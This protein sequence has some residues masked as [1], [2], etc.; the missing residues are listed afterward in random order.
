MYEIAENMAMGTMC[1]YTPY[2]DALPH[3]KCVLRCCSNFPHIDLSDQEPD[4]HHPNACLS[5]RFHIYHLIACCAVHGRRPLDKRKICHMC[6]K[7]P[8][9]VTR[10]KLYT[11]K[12]LVMVETYIADFNTIIYIPEIKN[13]A[14]HLPNIRIISMNQCGK[15]RREAFKPFSAKQDV[16]CC[17]DYSERVVASF[18]HQIQSSPMS[19]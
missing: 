10:T 3:W 7:D 2:Q 6:F 18:A 8:A 4:R 12:D 17:Y 19:R 5:I 16:L 9:T 15:T 1:A 14:F 13:L 11:R